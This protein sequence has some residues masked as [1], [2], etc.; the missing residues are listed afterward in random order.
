MRDIVAVSGILKSLCFLFPVGNPFFNV[1]AFESLLVSGLHRYDL[2]DYRRM[3]VFVWVSPSYISTSRWVDLV[4]GVRHMPL[5]VA[6]HVRT[7]RS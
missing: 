7:I 2:N 5:L 4:C 6:R 1:M 3:R